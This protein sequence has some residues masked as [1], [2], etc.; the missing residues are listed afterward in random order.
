MQASIQSR[1][2]IAEGFWM[3][4]EFTAFLTLDETNRVYIELY[5]FETEE[6][7]LMCE[8]FF[9]VDSTPYEH[10]EAI[11]SSS[12]QMIAVVLYNKEPTKVAQFKSF[13]IDFRKFNEEEQRIEEIVVN[14][15]DTA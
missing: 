14:E 13:I 9:L 1:N 8:P 2:F 7:S 3:Q 4:G 11:V 15:V 6:I 5:T 10:M 12:R